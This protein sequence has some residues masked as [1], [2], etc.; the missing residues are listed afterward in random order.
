MRIGEFRPVIKRAAV[1]MSCVVKLSRFAEDVAEIE[2][3]LYKARLQ[4]QSSPIASNGVVELSPILKCPTE[5]KQA[6]RILR[7]QPHRLAHET[8]GFPVSSHFQ[9]ESTT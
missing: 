5:I 9:R 8:S 7:I 2:M 3:R 4:L 1:A 6:F